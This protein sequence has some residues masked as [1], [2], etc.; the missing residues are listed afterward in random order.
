MVRKALGY[1]GRALEIGG[2]EP[3][4]VQTQ[5]SWQATLKAT[6]ERRLRI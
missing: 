1:C 3:V 5:R 4:Q 6:F 2:F